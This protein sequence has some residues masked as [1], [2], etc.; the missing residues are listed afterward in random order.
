M[1][2]TS[3]P[4]SFVFHANEL[5]RS[6]NS[7]YLAALALGASMRV[8]AGDLGGLSGLLLFAGA[9]RVLTPAD[10]GTP[11]TFL[12][13]SWRQVSRMLRKRTELQRLTPVSLPVRQASEYPLREGG[14][15][16]ELGTL[17]AAAIAMGIVESADHEDKLRALLE[18]FVERTLTLRGQ[19]GVGQASGSDGSVKIHSCSGP[20]SGGGDGAEGPT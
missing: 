20:S 10:R 18:A 6:T 15:F 11:L 5:R 17:E 7:G 2:H 4:V 13:G 8:H 16:D 14:R 9:S 19:A 1:L 3:A 12:D